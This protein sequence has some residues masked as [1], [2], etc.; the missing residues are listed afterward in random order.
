MRLPD[1]IIIGAAK[2]GTT[3]L[4]W[5]LAEH[6][7]V[8]MSPVKETNFFAWETDARG[9]PV[10]GNMDLHHFPVRSMSAYEKLFAGAGKAAAV[11]EASPI[12]L[13]CP[14]SAKRMQALL[15]AARIIC[16]LRH[17]VDRAYSDYLMYL[18]GRGERLDPRRDL[19]ATARWAQPESHWMRVSRYHDS[20]QRYFDAF[21]RDR[22]HVFLFDDLK[23]D[24]GGVVRETYRFLDVAADH[25][26]DFSTPYN[27]GGVPANM[28]LERAFTTAASIRTAVEPWLPKRATS[29]IRRIRA[30]NMQPPPRLPAVLRDELVQRHFRDDI[31]RTAELIGIDLD[32]WLATPSRDRSLDHHGRDAIAAG[33]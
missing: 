18:R 12:Y 5:Y 16:G 17:P 14:T 19:V 27:V 33:Q 28:L 29:W 4:Y 24:P 30:A 26:P 2:A 11:G 8:F 9:T 6:P 1:F 7:E 13:E 25:V 15:P 23:R 10:Y 31:A 22:I 21:P 32:H 20:L 3:A